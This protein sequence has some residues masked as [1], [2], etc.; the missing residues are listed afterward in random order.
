M[1][2]CMYCRYPF[3][4]MQDRWQR[5]EAGGSGLEIGLRPAMLVLR[6]G[7]AAKTHQLISPLLAPAPPVCMSTVGRQ[8]IKA[9][10][11]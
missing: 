11:C 7:A 10:L 9:V 2:E 6:E 4:C 1:V 8:K 5:D 3:N